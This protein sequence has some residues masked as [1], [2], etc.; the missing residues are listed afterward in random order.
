MCT[1][2]KGKGNSRCHVTNAYMKNTNKGKKYRKS[3]LK[4]FL[5]SVAKK[6]REKPHFYDTVS[7]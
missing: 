3:T 4:M 1:K 7:V 6:K 2:C 5:L